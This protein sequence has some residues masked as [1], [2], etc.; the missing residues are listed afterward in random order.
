[1]VGLGPGLTP[2]GDDFLGGLLFAAHHLRAA[3]PSAFEQAGDLLRDFLQEARLLTNRIS[4]TIL[5]DLAHGHGPAPLHDLIDLLW[6]ANPEP[7]WRDSA[8]HLIHIGHTSGWDMLAGMLTG[9]L[10]RNNLAS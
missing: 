5:A 7:S 9:M 6:Q 4:H 8:Q 3:Y 2:S 1:L 10:L